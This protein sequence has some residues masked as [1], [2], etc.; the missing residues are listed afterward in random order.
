[1]NAPKKIAARALLVCAAVLF[2]PKFALAT[3]PVQHWTQPG[4]AEVY[5]VESPAVPM[6]D[7]QIDFD[8]GSRRDRE[9]VLDDCEHEL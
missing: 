8:A 4:G 9:Y 3:I 2:G 6:L 5:L 7:V 1:M